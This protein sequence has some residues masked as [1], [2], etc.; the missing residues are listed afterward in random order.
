MSFDPDKAYA[1]LVKAGEDWADADAAASLL[2]ETKK[3]ML[4]QL[5]LQSAEKTDAARETQALASPQYKE[6][7][8]E[9][10]GARKHAI[11]LRVRYDSAKTLAEHRRTQE[12]TR[13]AEAQIL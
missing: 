8:Q 6:F 11:K 5:K 13:R 9:M 10:V 7:L 12:S 3:P 2:E 1:A 4:A